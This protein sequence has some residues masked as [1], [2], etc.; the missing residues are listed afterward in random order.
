MQGYGNLPPRPQCPPRRRPPHFGRVIC[1]TIAIVAAS[2]S[3]TVAGCSLPTDTQPSRIVIPPTDELST[4]T[5]TES[6]STPSTSGTDTAQNLPDWTIGRVVALAPRVDNSR[7]HQGSVTP[8]SPLQDS[9]GFHFSIPDGTVNCSTGTNGSATLACRIDDDDDPDTSPSRS[10]SSRASAACD[11]AGDFATLSSEGPQR[12][13]CANRYPVL[14]RSSIV[15]F[16]HTISI[17]RFSCLV[18]TVGLF[19]LESRSKAGFSVTSGRYRTIYAADR[20]PESLVSL[21]PEESDET[22]E[23]SSS[24]TPTTRTSRTS[25]RPASPRNPTSN[26]STA[27]TR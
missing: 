20:A 5:E 9:S 11:W 16:G 13:A 3:I 6:A 17:S 21:T 8:D 25:S 2:V 23:I 10:A 22:S 24:V 1:A 12:G 15:D 4:V 19:C 26:S 27:P 7:F 18:E 14:Y